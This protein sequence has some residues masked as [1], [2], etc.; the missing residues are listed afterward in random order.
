MRYGVLLRGN[1]VAP[2]CT[3]AESIQI[4]VLRR[5]RVTAE[6]EIPLEG[7]YGIQLNGLLAEH[8]VDCLVCG[9]IDMATR[10]SLLSGRITIIDNVACTVAD[11]L[12]GLQAGSL[13]PGFGFQ[14]GHSPCPEAPVAPP[15]SIDPLPDLF[16]D[17]LA[18]REK[19]CLTGGTCPLAKD[20]QSPLS[21]GSAEEMLDAATDIACEDERLLCRL[22][23]LIYFCLEMNYRRIGVAFCMELLEPT[24]ILVG[25]LKRFFE[26]YAVG[27]KIG[28]LRVDDPLGTAGGRGAAR[29][30]GAIACNPL[31]QADVLNRLGRDLNV[32]VG[33]CMGT[34]CI[35]ARKSDA[36]V[37]TLIVKDR[38]LAH[39]PIGA[40]YSEYYL[41]EASRAP[42]TK[43]EETR[44]GA[45]PSENV[46]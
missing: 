28:G 18:C 23:E 33:L 31:G 14:H 2:R 7:C 16:S 9:G 17:C 32:M 1:R 19:V 13:R 34:D 4:V 41:A 36:P 44:Q 40:L 39:N 35:F 38:S 3:S 46:L 42:L 11:V 24:E 27:C 5:K 30:P 29:E 10:E 37:T 45:R 22:S 21:A 20:Q 6:A 26:V 43:A 15:A 25:V 8:R 12:E